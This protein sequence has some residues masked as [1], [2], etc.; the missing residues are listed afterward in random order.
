MRGRPD[1]WGCG[2]CGSGPSALAA[3]LRSSV[4]QPPEPRS[5]S[6]CLV[7]SSSGRQVPLVRPSSPGYAASFTGRAGHAIWTDLD[8]A[9]LPQTSEP[10]EKSRLTSV[11]SDVSL[12][13]RPIYLCCIA[14]PSRAP[15]RTRA[16]DP[17]LGEKSH[18]Q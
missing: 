5:N 14:V 4:P 15:E 11:V 3:G 12:S 8:P 13:S 18:D 16:T 2:E 6:L 10:A 1:T 7:A 17:A 9:G